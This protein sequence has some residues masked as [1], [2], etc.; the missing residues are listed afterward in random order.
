MIAIYT[1]LMYGF[2]EKI[3]DLISLDEVTK[4]TEI[5]MIDYNLLIQL[6]LLSVQKNNQMKIVVLTDEY[7][8]DEAISVYEQNIEHYI[9]IKSGKDIDT[10][11]NMFKNTTNRVDEIEIN[12]EKKTIV[13]NG[14]VIKLTSKEILI[15]EYLRQNRGEVCH[16]QDILVDVLKYHRD[17]DTRL[18]DVYVKYLRTKLGVEG[19]KIKTVRGKGYIYE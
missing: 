5:L 9:V 8:H 13:V 2:T 12:K 14:D 17:T 15:Y 3:E 1:D 16:R 10:I 7:N 11:Y 18:I 6:D 19:K 4:Y